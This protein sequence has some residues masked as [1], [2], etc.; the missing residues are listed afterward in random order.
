VPVFEEVVAGRVVWG[1]GGQVLGIHIGGGFKVD[2]LLLG[3][4]GKLDVVHGAG[5]EVLELGLGIAGEGEVH[6][7][8]VSLLG[9]DA[10]VGTGL[11]L[12]HPLDLL[13]PVGEG[14]GRG[15]TLP[16]LLV[17][18]QGELVLV[19]AVQLVREIV[20]SEALPERGPGGG[21]EHLV[22][23]IG[24]VGNIAEEDPGESVA[25]LLVKPV[26]NIA[27]DLLLKLVQNR[28]KV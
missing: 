9:G 10:N 26:G 7:V 19:S 6:T 27:G 8:H 4:Q 21:I 25:G 18:F 22:P 17:A 11:L 5:P 15:D 3:I 12:P 24:V 16:V 20:V 2:A 23:D 14:G 13:L 1:H 28:R